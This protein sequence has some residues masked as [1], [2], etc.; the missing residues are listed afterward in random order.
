[1]KLNSFEDV[2]NEII[3]KSIGSI[4][5]IDDD[6]AEPFEPSTDSETE[7]SRGVY[8]SFRR[9][10]R[11]ID[12]Y[13]F[14]D[15]E[16][17][18][19]RSNYTLEGR[20]LLILDWQLSK[21]GVEHSPTVAI[22][23]EAIKRP[24]LHFICIYT[25]TPSRDFSEIIYAINSYFA[26]FSKDILEEDK[27]AIEEI[28]ENNGFEFKKIFDEDVQALLKEMVLYKDRAG[29]IFKDLTNKIQEKSNNEVFKEI[30]QHFIERIKKKVYNSL[31]YCFCGLGFLLAG[32]DIRG[33]SI[34]EAEEIKNNVKQNFL[35][36]NHTIIVI[37]NKTEI[38]PQN[39]Y[40]R[41]KQAIIHNSGNFLTL[42]ALEMR[43]LFKES[44]GFIGKDIDSINELAF[45]H[46]RENSIPSE[47]FYDFLRELWKSQ[48]ASFLYDEERQPKIFRTLDEYKDQKGI[49][50]QMTQFLASPQEYQQ[51]LGKLNFYYN[52][53][54]TTRKKNDEVRFGDIFRIH[55]GDD[56]TD[57]YLLCITAHCDCLYAQDKINNMFY[58]VKG[59]KGNLQNALRGGDTEF[60][61]YITNS[62]TIDVINWFNKP[63]TVYIS[64]KFNNIQNSIEVD[65]G[66]DRRNLI[67]HSTLKENY[68]QRIANNAFV[69]PFHVGIYF[70]DTKSLK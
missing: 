18:Q 50:E 43:N 7:L 20:D 13:K 60:N 66:A 33:S 24:N 4:M 32:E 63:F 51:H 55:N 40:E 17:W 23:A 52:N 64:P 59:S 3:S 30:R 58:F 69:Y 36:V 29:I 46:H 14:K 1:M 61:S 26:P 39:L 49:N 19:N 21:V 34:N 28:L 48:A 8:Q 11:S 10:D 45:F 56:I 65:L 47:S 70:A 2:A 54:V 35:V 25:S 38:K 31:P 37:N 41:F 53:L 16:D 5:F 67:Y 15:F 12:L 44:S 6:L 9:E 22:I 68:A 62:G 27:K 42:M 57:Q